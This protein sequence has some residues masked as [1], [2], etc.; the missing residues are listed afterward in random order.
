[1]IKELNTFSLLHISLIIYSAILF[2]VFTKIPKYIPQKFLNSY[3]TS[4]GIFLILLKIFDTFIL[5][6]YEGYRFIEAL[7]LHICNISLIV[8]ALFLITRKEI[9][10]NILYFFSFGAILAIIFPDFSTF[11]IWYY[12]FIY[13][14]THTFEYITIIYSL[15]YLN[16]SVTKQG[17][18]ATKI[19][20]S[21]LIFI[22]LIINYNFN[23]N[24]MFLN[25]YASSFLSFIKPI[26]LYNILIIITYFIVYKTMYQYTMRKQN[27]LRGDK[28]EN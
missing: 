18:D 8:G 4:L 24:Y 17:Y 10:F 25:N 15:I 20:M 9:L 14:T 16:V 22:N 5:L 26:W 7:P 13:M 23:T 21:I 3:T 6:K 27:R 12:P 1:M 19:F 2:I 11:N 28:Y